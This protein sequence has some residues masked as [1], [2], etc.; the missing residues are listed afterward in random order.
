MLAQNILGLDGNMLTFDIFVHFGTLLAVI[1]VF[2]RSIVSICRE[3]MTGLQSVATRQSTLS[4]VYA[5]SP[6]F[7]M[8][9]AIIIGT[10]PA[11]IV[12][13]TINDLVESLFSA[14]FPVLIALG[15]TGLVLV[16]TFFARCGENR[17][18]LVRGLVIGLAQAV[19]I[20]PGISRSGSTISA[21][22][23]LGVERREAGEF[24]FLLA[25]PAIAGATVLAVKDLA[26]GVGTI[27]PAVMIAGVAAS[28]VSGYFSLV[29]LMKIIRRGKIGYFGFYCLAVSV[30]GMACRFLY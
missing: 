23:F 20:I 12:G 9:V 24:S 7:R 30:A 5:A 13:L 15:I 25:I 16:T 4:G 1:A 6:G 17:V 18:G 11:V 29:L 19:A 21:A 27:S 26:G 22:L 28:F 8:A 14:V 2:F 10:I 3:T